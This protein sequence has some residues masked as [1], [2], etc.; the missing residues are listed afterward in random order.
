MREYLRRRPVRVARGMTRTVY[1]LGPYAFKTPSLRNG[2]PG[3]IGGML[4]NL[5]ER[6]LSRWN[7]HSLCPVLFAD[8]FGL[9]VVM[10]R[11]EIL[12]D[13]EF[14]RVAHR[15]PRECFAERKPSSWGYVAGMLVAVDYGN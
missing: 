12:S 10:P 4:G 2:L 15:I 3:W 7:H 1:L 5:Q 8:P 13:D 9:V 6:A 14:S 11:A